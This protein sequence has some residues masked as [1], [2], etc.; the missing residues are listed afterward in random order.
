MFPA[1]GVFILTVFD[2]KPNGF[3]SPGLRSVSGSPI[4]LRCVTC[5][6]TGGK[7][8]P[9]IILGQDGDGANASASFSLT[10]VET[11]ELGLFTPGVDK[12]PT[13]TDHLVDWI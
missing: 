5:D 10:L 12:L 11:E 9:K 1:L 6:A 13:K 4:G 7:D 8:K 2:F 3:R